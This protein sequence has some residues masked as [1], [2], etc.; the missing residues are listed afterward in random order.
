MKKT[1]QKVVAQAI[2]E[3][4]DGLP[5]QAMREMYGVTITVDRR[6]TVRIAPC[7]LVEGEPLSVTAHVLKDGREVETTTITLTDS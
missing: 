6:Y 2:A 3:W 5:T 1:I 4:R 7:A